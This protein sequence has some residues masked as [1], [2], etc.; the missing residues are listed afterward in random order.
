MG[1]LT[2]IVVGLGIRATELVV[3]FR[4]ENGAKE[5][6]EVLA[7]WELLAT[8]Q[9]VLALVHAHLLDRLS[10]GSGNRMSKG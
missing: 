4:T 9:P 2:L 3:S 1:Q 10:L 5:V 8:T 6:V 7:G